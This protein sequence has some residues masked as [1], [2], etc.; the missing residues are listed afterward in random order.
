VQ[1]DVV[2]MLEDFFETGFTWDEAA[3]DDVARRLAALRASP[4]AGLAEGFAEIRRRLATGEMPERLRR[5]VEAVVYSKLWKVLEAVRAGL[6]EGEQ[7]SRV[8][9]LNRGLA[10]VLEAEADPIISG[11]TPE[12][13][14]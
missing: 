8:E 1:P 2:T 11:D 6:P 12:P 10:R 3:L 14:G 13:P 5:E 4:V 9:V 7:R